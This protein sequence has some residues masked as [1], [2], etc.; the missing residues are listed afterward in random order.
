MF[1]KKIKTLIAL[2]LI[3]LSAQVSAQIESEI[4]SYVDSTEIL[5]NNGKRLLLENVRD[6]NYTKAAEIYSYLNEK[7]KLKQ[8]EAFT[9]NEHLAITL[10]TSDWYTF[11]DKAENIKTTNKTVCYPRGYI[12]QQELF[13][14]IRKN[15]E[16]ILQKTRDAKL[17]SEDLDLLEIYLLLFQPKKDEEAYNNKVKLF[18]KNYPNSKYNDFFKEYL[19]APTSQQSMTFSMGAAGIFPQGNLKKMFDS[20]VG[21]SM[22]WD[23]C[24]N[25]VYASLFFNFSNPKL[26]TP[27]DAVSNDG[28]PFSFNTTHSFNYFEGGLKGG[29]YLYRGKYFHWAPYAAIGGIT[30][31][32]NLYKSSKDNDKELKILNSF[33]FGPGIHT[34]V[35]LFGYK[36]SNQSIYGSPAGY[37]SLKLDAGYNVITNQK[38]EIF[39]GNTISAALTLVWGIGYF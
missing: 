28:T 3:L 26:L 38:F 24:I 36:S 33:H 2:F 34:E 17:K 4:K 29:Y 16:F 31:E 14:E 1:M 5:V 20:S 27:F 10:L 39:K 12:N 9:Y 21:F 13:D 15:N 32:S 7:T 30:L 37:F 6:L 25:K 23:F 22:A 11:L 35:K 8:C 18:K 19:P